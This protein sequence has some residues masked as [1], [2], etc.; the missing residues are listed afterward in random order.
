MEKS[1][2]QPASSHGDIAQLGERCVRNAEVRGS[3]PPISISRSRHY[4]IRCNDGILL[5]TKALF[6]AI[7]ATIPARRRTAGMLSAFSYRKWIRI[8]NFAGSMGKSHVPIFYQTSCDDAGRHVFHHS[9]HVSDD[10]C[11]TGRTVYK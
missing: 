2:I 8:E 11:C 7:I 9:A 6:A 10:A 5:F 4:T 3:N 1:V